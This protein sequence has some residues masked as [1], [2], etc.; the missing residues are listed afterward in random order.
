[1]AAESGGMRCAV[2]PTLAYPSQRRP[3]TALFFCLHSS[4]ARIVGATHHPRVRG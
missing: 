2:P 3:R 4:E 1:M